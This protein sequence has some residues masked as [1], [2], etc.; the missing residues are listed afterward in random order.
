L[1]HGGTSGIGVAAIQMARAYGAEVFATAGTPEK[2]AAVT[3][4]GAR[5][6]NHRSEDFEDIVRAEGGVDVILDMV[7][8]RYVQKNLAILRDRGRCVQIAFLE[9]ARAEVD[10]TRLMLKRLTLTGSTLR[11]RSIEEKARLA[12]AVEATV[13]PWVAAG[14]VKPVIDRVYPLSEAEA[15]HAR[16][17][18]GDHIG[19]IVLTTGDAP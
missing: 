15:A 18:S 4:M 12:A 13:W 9:G 8:G 5:A 11:S 2:C 1:V 16:L 3:S 6:I 14:L 17:Q 19:K 10:L 7:G